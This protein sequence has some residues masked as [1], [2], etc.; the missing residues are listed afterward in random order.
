MS[1]SRYLTEPCRRT[2]FAPPPTH[3]RRWSVRTESFSSAAASRSL[4]KGDIDWP[5]LS[6]ANH[7]QNGERLI[8]HGMKIFVGLFCTPANFIS[9]MSSP[10]A[11]NRKGGSDRSSPISRIAGVTPTSL[12]ILLASKLNGGIVSAGKSVFHQR[13]G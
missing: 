13:K 10:S 5:K 1:E 11:L 9:N 6:E 12:P 8:R 4:S 7:L 3:R 2:N